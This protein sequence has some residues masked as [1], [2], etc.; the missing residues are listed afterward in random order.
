MSTNNGK[1]EYSKRVTAEFV[2][3]EGKEILKVAMQKYKTAGK[4]LGDTQFA[5]ELLKEL[6]YAHRDFAVA[7]PIALR[8]ICYYHMY[9][10]RA[11]KA[12]LAKVTGKT[13]N[14]DQYLD[15]AADYVVLLHRFCPKSNPFVRATGRLNTAETQKFWLLIRRQLQAEKA[16]FKKLMDNATKK[17][18]A[19]EARYERMRRDELMSYLKREFG[20]TT[21]ANSNNAT[22]DYSSDNIIIDDATGVKISNAD[23]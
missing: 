4:H 13:P 1:I 18:E 14:E 20:E 15:F 7:Y 6:Q 2:M 11:M 23:D 3:N 8:Y 10:T 19:D 9:D 21:E 5:D 17:V 16:Q 22:L 12:Y